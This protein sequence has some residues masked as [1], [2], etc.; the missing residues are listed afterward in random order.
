MAV[1]DD[2]FFPAHSELY[3]LKKNFHS[4]SLS[5]TAL[6]CVRPPPV[7]LLL[8]VLLLWVVK[9]GVTRIFPG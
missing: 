6:E 3:A 4:R 8:C 9:K 5:E 7:L 2:N 1:R